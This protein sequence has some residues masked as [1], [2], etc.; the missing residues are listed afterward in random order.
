MS[1]T[2]LLK[3]M[4]SGNATKDTKKISDIPNLI[5]STILPR[6]ILFTGRCLAFSIN[7]SSIQMAAVK[8]FFNSRIIIDIRKSYIPVKDANEDSKNVFINQEIAAFIDEHATRNTKIVISLSGIE[9]SFRTFL[10]PFLKKNKLTSA[11]QFEVKK[12]IPFPVEDCIYDYQPIYKIADDKRT[13]LKIALH[14]ATKSYINE[15]LSFFNNYEIDVKS[16]VHSHSTVGQLLRYLPNFDNNTPYT[17]LNIEKNISEIAFYKGSSLEFFHVTN[18][19]TSML[20]QTSSSTKMEYLAETLSSEINSS[21]DFYSGQYRSSNHS[22][23]YIHGDLSYSDEL[24]KLLINKMGTEFKRFPIEKLSFIQKQNF[25][26]LETVS[27]CLPALAAASCNVKTINL[28]PE[29]LKTLQNI[30]KVNFI[31]R[32]AITTMVILLASCWWGF[33]DII[34]TKED[35]NQILHKQVED[36]RSSNAYHTYN[37]LKSKIVTTQTYLNQTQQNPSFLSL[38]LKELSLITKDGIFLSR[39]YYENKNSD[40]HITIN[41]KTISTTVP[42]EILIAE[43]IENLN[44]SPYYKDVTLVRHNKNELKKGF[45]IEFTLTMRGI[46]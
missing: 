18:N 16:I 23:I 19:G 30:K 2:G 46:I 43:Y 35:H 1:L 33:N 39:L 22:K 38:N 29:K 26:D 7:Q 37:L 24:I 8:H 40:N 15:N 3:K 12:Q 13:K 45:E 21:L 31:G 20:G 34:R 6:K 11:I 17:L 32:F 44:A 9:T 42:P 5:E 27:V 25:P 41:G 36:F 10:I 4:K 14:A 28:L